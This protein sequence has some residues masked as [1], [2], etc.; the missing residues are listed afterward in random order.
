[1]AQTK[2]Q[3]FETV[4]TIIFLYLILNTL[5]VFPDLQLIIKLFS[6]SGVTECSFNHT[7]SYRYYDITHQCKTVG[8]KI[9]CSNNSAGTLEHDVCCNN[10][11]GDCD[12]VDLRSQYMSCIKDPEDFCKESSHS[13]YPEVCTTGYYSEFGIMLLGKLYRNRNK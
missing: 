2:V 6:A 8:A 1:M 4:A 12:C 3:L 7:L 13:S 11:N 5:D 10:A 9:F